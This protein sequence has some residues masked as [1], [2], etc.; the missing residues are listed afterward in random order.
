MS[1]MLV[2]DW[3]EMGNLYREHSCQIL[4]HLAKQFQRRRFECERLP[5]DV[6]Q[7][8]TNAHMTFKG[9]VS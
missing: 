1:A 5:D 4:V 3:D 2:A 8:M 9:Q 6:R 7:V